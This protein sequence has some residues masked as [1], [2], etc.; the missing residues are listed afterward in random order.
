L[1]ALLIAVP[2]A[3]LAGIVVFTLRTDSNVARPAGW[4][5]V[6]LIALA[7][8]L[9]IWLIWRR[10][11]QLEQ[12]CAAVPPAAPGE[13]ASCHVC[14]GPVAAADGQ[15]V[16]RCRFCQADNIVLPRVLQRSQHAFVKSAQELIRDL[17]RLAVEKNITR[18]LLIPVAVA[19]GGPLISLG[20]FSILEKIAAGR[21]PELVTWPSKQGQCLRL[22][23]YD[24]FGRAYITEY[25][26][27]LFSRS[28]RLSDHPELKPF[29]PK[30][31]RGKKVYA[32]AGQ[33]GVVSRVSA[34]WGTVRIQITLP[35]S[36]YE[37]KALGACLARGPAPHRIGSLPFRGDEK[38]LLAAA[39]TN[40]YF[41]AAEGQRLFVAKRP[42]GPIAPVYI[43]TD[44]EKSKTRSY[45]VAS[46][47]GSIRQL[48]VSNRHVILLDNKGGLARLNLA[49][50]AAP[51][52]TTS[53]TYVKI[54]KL[55]AAT[56]G[57]R[58]M[59]V[60]GNHV[61][62]ASDR[63]VISRV[64]IG[65]GEKE[66]VATGQMGVLVVTVGGQHV[67]WASFGGIYRTRIGSAK[68]ERLG[69][70]AGGDVHQIIATRRGLLWRAVKDDA[71]ALYRFDFGASKPQRVGAI[72][73]ASVMQGG[74]RG[75]V[76]VDASWHQ[77]GV[78]LH[79]AKTGVGRSVAPS[80][81]SVRA[82]ALS[83]SQV[84]WAA[85]VADPQDK[86]PSKSLV[87]MQRPLQ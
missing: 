11:R 48:E 86:T 49:E 87:F 50:L 53:L 63:G 38:S 25:D 79:D 68:P 65:G 26:H 7:V 1:L 43:S 46:G 6:P 72:K 47:F 54:E 18:V 39:A 58:Q 44:P 33:F 77:R 66:R 69:K 45:F 76:W 24:L 35:D 40:K 8:G 78:W 62:F 51:G 42:S 3:V 80:A 73:E 9:A 34:K 61:Y 74:Q 13:P 22:V 55:P 41:L 20:V 17:D 84:F 2:S 36:K 10:Q 4:A 14:G 57:A 32:K 83:S 64:P 52:S 28:P 30:A 60:A 59:G 21:A 70:D 85:L 82:V 23:Q 56:A 75:A 16:V 81:R 19:V 31:L 67:Y 5:C 71:Q 37:T 15:A 12:S 27:R 29:A